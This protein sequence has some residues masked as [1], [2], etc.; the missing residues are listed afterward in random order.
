M[1]G[2][3]RYL[4]NI[5]SYSPFLLKFRCHGNKGGSKVNITVQYGSADNVVKAVNV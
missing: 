2:S 1:Q 4:V 5:S 3:W